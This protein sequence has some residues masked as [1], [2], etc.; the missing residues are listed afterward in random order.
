[1]DQNFARQI[2]TIRYQL[3]QLRSALGVNNPNSAEQVVRQLR[4][5]VQQFVLRAEA[6]EQRATSLEQH[7]IALQQTVAGLVAAANPTPAA[8]SDTGSGADALSVS[9]STA[10]GD[11]GQSTEILSTTTQ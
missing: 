7:V 10:L 3:D 1:M 9:V 8:M 5:T 11:S 4:G 6:L 2:A